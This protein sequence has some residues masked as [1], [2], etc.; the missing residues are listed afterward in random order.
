M[1]KVLRCFLIGVFLPGFAFSQTNEL[2]QSYKKQYPDEPAVY[3]NRSEVLSI[4]IEKDT[5]RTFAELTEDLLML[6]DQAEM[7]SGKKVYGSHFNQIKNIA[8]KTLVWDKS[9]YKS[10]EVSDF[11]K[12]SD[13]DHSIFYDDSYYYSFNFPSLALQ[14]RTQLSYTEE[15]KDARF[16]SGFV[17]PSYLPVGSVSYTIKAAKG[18]ELYYEVINDPQKKINF[19]MTEKSGAVFYEWTA[20]NLEALKIESGSPSVRYYAPQL[21]CY[22]KSFTAKNGKKNVLSNLNDLYAWYATFLKGLN[23]STSPELIDIVQKLKASSKS[24]LDL[25]KKVYYWVQDNIQYI[26]FEQGMRGLIPHP[27]AYV[28]E[29]RFG[30]C[31]DM[32]SLIVTML[33][34]SNVKSYY[35]WIGTRDIPFQYS[36]LPTPLVDNHMIATYIA[37]DGTYYFLDGTDDY[38]PFG[39]PSS[40]TQGKEALIGLDSTH[41]DIRPVPVIAK[42]KSV[43]TDSMKVKIVGNN[44][45]GHGSST[46]IGYAKDFA[47]YELMRTDEEDLQKYVTRIIG[48]GNN[49]FYLDNYKVRFLDDKDKPT[50]IEYD[51]RIGDY[52]Q[53]VG[54]EIYVNLNLNKDHYNEVIDLATRKTPRKNEYQYVKYEVIDMALPSGYSVEYLPENAK[55]DSDLFGYD[56]RYVQKGN[57]ITCNKTLYVNYLLLLPDQFKKW[58]EAITQVSEAYKESIILK[59]K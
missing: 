36:K 15:I 47:A 29:K 4:L 10:M 3:L 40:M 52:F 38:L 19:K 5:L 17:F 20:Q 18:V 50:S 26:A 25:V 1:H 58:N 59:Q 56:I 54:N 24:E 23:K 44:L 31:K 6:K 11:K 35:T 34:L 16:I 27:G 8:A 30:D 42:E 32:A 39:F 43:M 57:S 28:C 14:N 7:F 37:K 55:Y 51:F 2:F 22:V 49:K 33:R 41:F 9:R 53:K 48:K 46:L 45:V 13:R 12:N 21:L